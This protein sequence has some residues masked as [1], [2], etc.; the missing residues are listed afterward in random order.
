MKRLVP[1]LV[2]ALSLAGCGA[3]VAS[4][5]KSKGDVGVPN[6]DVVRIIHI[7]GVRCAVITGRRSSGIDCD[8]AGAR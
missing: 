3:G 6:G 5:D 2:L 1:A 8:W 7:D 4:P